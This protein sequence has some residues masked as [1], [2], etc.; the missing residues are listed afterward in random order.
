MDRSIKYSLSRT[1]LFPYVKFFSNDDPFEGRDLL[2]EK[3]GKL[4]I[5]RIKKVLHGFLSFVSHI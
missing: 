1:K 2:S 4:E 3:F 5:K